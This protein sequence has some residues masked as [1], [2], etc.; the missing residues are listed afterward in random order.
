MSGAQPVADLIDSGPGDLWPEAFE[1]YD[2]D[3]PEC[4][5]QVIG[6]EVQHPK[7]SCVYHGRGA[8]E[9]ER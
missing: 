1:G 6:G 9:E 7:S 3:A 2:P 5:C 4:P 8:E